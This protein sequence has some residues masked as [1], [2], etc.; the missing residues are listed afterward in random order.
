M[1]EFMLLQSVGLSTSLMQPHS[2]RHPV[3][4]SLLGTHRIRTHSRVRTKKKH[5]ILSGKNVTAHINRAQVIGKMNV[6]T[7]TC[8]SVQ[9]KAYMALL[10]D[11]KVILI[12]VNYTVICTMT[13]I[14]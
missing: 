10:S 8:I 7:V 12:C 4:H 5:L 11:I 14:L 1:C 13:K 3:L 2:T 6:C 9:Q